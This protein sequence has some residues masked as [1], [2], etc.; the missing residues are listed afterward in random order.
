M[1]R[2]DRLIDCQVAIGRGNRQVAINNL[3]AHSN[4]DDLQIAIE[5]ALN[6]KPIPALIFHIL[7][8]YYLR[9]HQLS[10]LCWAKAHSR[11]PLSPS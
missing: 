3:S 8:Q 10:I 5:M 4:K 6:P 11:P 7:L 2:N 1:F 9:H